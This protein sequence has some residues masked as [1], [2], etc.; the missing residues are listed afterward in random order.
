MWLATT[1]LIPKSLH[2]AM[3]TLPLAKNVENGL[4][5]HTAQSLPKVCLKS[6]QSQSEVCPKSAQ[7]LPKVCQKSA[8]SLPKV[9]QSLPKVCQKSAKSLPKMDNI[10]QGTVVATAS[11]NVQVIFY[12]FC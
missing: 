6:V 9:C 3:M 8:K 5:V 7:S 10:I 4:D 12:A 11:R 2:Q 1:K